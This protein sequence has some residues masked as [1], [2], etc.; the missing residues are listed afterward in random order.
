MRVIT[1]ALLSL[2]LLLCVVTTGCGTAPPVEPG[3]PALLAFL[4]RTTA[5][6]SSAVVCVSMSEQYRAKGLRVIVV[7][8]GSADELTNLT[9]DWHLGRIELRPASAGLASRYA[10]TSVPTTLLLDADGKVRQRWQGAL[11][12]QSVAIPVQQIME[13]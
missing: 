8:E 3:K 11:V 5:S 13:R 2:A 4:D 7:T 12:P 6:R 9:H 10:V 1:L